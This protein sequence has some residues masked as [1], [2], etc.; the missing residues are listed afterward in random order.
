MRVLWLQFLVILCLTILRSA[1]LIGGKLHCAESNQP[2][3]T[4]TK[5]SVDGYLQQLPEPFLVFC[6]YEDFIDLAKE[7]QHVNEEQDT[8]KDDPEDKKCPN[9]PTEMNQILLRSKDFLR[10]LP[11]SNFNSLQY[12][13]EHLKQVAD[14]TKENKMDYKNL[15]VIFGPSLIRPRPTTAPVTISSLAEYSNQAQLMEFLITYSEKIFHGSPQPQVAMGSAERQQNALQEEVTMSISI[16]GEHSS[17]VTPPK[18]PYTEPARS[19]GEASERRSS[20]SNPLAPARAP[21]MLQPQHWTPLYK[22][23]TPPAMSGD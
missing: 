10:Q 3:V 22:R 13:I 16:S 18:E 4:S 9:L 23:R 19:T 8:E 1:I 17:G 11:T 7:I 12:L 21:R 5:G 20:H 15:G 2:F 6:L 14:C